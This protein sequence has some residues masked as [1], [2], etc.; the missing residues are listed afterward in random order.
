MNHIKST[1]S[2]KD[3]EN[4]SGIKAHTI[5]I[6][7]KRYN[8]LAP[9]RTDTNIRVYSLKS[10][11]KLLNV[12]FLMSKGYKISKIAALDEPC[13][14]K[15]LEG[16]VND[17]VSKDHFISNLKIAMLNFDVILFNKTYDNVINA[18]DFSI[19]FQNYFIPF[20]DDIGLLWQSGSIEPS[21]EHFISNLIK[22]KTLMEIHKLQLQG[23]VNDDILFVLFL[24]EDEIHDLGLT[25][26]QFEIFKKG[27]NPIM[28]GTSV[29][30]TSL[31]SFVNKK[32]KIVFLSYFTVKPEP[33]H[34]VPY[35]DAFYNDLLENKN[36][37]LWV[38]GRQ[39]QYLNKE[40]YS[41][42]KIHL[43]NS[44]GQVIQNLE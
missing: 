36:T 19:V 7:E 24:P 13:F 34:V 27:F 44:L 21:H 3:L 31:K 5:R 33:E 43:F 41:P 16:L 6:W 25:Y 35:L 22:Q 42:K 17:C 4:L 10:L 11:K 30:T 40:E 8:L 12:A 29:P 20:L 26:L 37:E 32:G 18:Y 39:I 38:L 1:F 28:L 9:E 15:T 14:E 2:I 23:F